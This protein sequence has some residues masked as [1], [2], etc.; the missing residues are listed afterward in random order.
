MVSCVKEVIDYNYKL[1]VFDY[2]DTIDLR[3]ATQTY[4]KEYFLKL[5]NHFKF[6]KE[7]GKK[8]AIIS[9][10]SNLT[11]NLKNVNIYQYFDYIYSPLIIPLDEYY[12][13]E[14]KKFHN[15]RVVML[16][17]RVIVYEDKGKVLGRILEK[18][19]IDKKEAIF[20]DD[21]SY[22]IKSVN[23]IGVEAILVDPIIGISFDT[24]M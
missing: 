20:F 18:L 4:R 8:L 11:N 21:I 2:D 9:Y 24:Y 7:K 5:V 1:F 13:V 12:N 19:K 15:E 22:N 3:K 6:L 16:R 23:K 10:N 14:N 17:N